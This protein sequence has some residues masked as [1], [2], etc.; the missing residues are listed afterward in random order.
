M[1]T[2]QT[3]L[4]DSQAQISMY[5]EM[6]G[7]EVIAFGTLCS[8]SQSSVGLEIKEINFGKIVSY[9]IDLATGNKNFYF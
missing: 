2:N 5:M 9:L 4:R 3:I 1:S 6:F 7:S 8:S